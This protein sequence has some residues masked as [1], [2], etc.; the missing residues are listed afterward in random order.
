MDRDLEELLE[1]T[2]TIVLSPE[3]VDESHIRMAVANGVI[4]DGRV[5]VDALRSAK[6]VKEAAE[7][8]A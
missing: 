5:T 4:S 7:G 2:K 3:D 1:R 8:K 6:A